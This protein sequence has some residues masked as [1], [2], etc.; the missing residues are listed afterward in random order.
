MNINQPFLHWTNF[1]TNE[2]LNC[3]NSLMGSQTIQHLRLKIIYRA[4][5][6][7]PISLPLC[8]YIYANCLLLSFSCAVIPHF[9]PGNK[10]Y[11]SLFN[12]YFF[13]LDQNIKRESG[14]KVQT[15]NINAAKVSQRLLMSSIPAYTKLQE[16]ALNQ[17]LV[18]RVTQLA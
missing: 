2:S 15:G 12:Y 9:V 10:M 14:R 11:I 18:T 4:V 5:S 3:V 16:V 1:I 17:L 8:I 7:M 6:S 13:F